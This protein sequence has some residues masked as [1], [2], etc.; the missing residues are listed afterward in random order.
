[1]WE[2]ILRHY[3]THHRLRLTS[4][5]AWFA[6]SS[7]LEEAITRAALAIDQRGKRCGHQRLIPKHTLQ[8]A[9]GA[10]LA[11]KNAILDQAAFLLS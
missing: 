7:N 1:M 2:P 4:E 6:G 5:E 10:L 11:Q 8:K 9:L 3:D